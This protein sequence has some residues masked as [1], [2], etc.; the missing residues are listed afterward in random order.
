M[1]LASPPSLESASRHKRLPRHWHRAAFSTSAIAAAAAATPHCAQPSPPPPPPHTP[2]HHR[3]RSLRRHWHQ[4]RHHP[5]HRSRRRGLH[6]RGLHFHCPVRSPVHR[7][8]LH[9]PHRPPPPPSIHAPTHAQPCS[10]LPTAA[11]AISPLPARLRAARPNSGFRDTL[12]GAAPSP[13]LARC[14]R[15]E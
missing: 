3:R 14:G 12:T 8:L 11:L 9:C 2:L 7:R 5:A 6:R 13:F 15:K 1:A 10:A 4:S